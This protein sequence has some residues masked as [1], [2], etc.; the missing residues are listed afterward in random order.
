MALVRT[1]TE[2][3]GKLNHPPNPTVEYAREK[4]SRKTKKQL[5]KKHNPRNGQPGI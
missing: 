5:E 2:E 4:K 1:H 3:T